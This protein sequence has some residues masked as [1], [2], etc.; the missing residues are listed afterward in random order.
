MPLNT[1]SICRPGKFGNPFKVTPD[2][3][4]EQAV[5]AFRHWIIADDNGVRFPEEKKRIRDNLHTLK[6]KNL[7]CFCKAGTACHGDVLIDLANPLEME[8]IYPFPVKPKV[9]GQVC[10]P[11][12]G[13]ESIDASH[14]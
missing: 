6:G 10:E 3:S 1:V 2:R 7:A 12:A 4:A 5:T 14:E 8:L 9:F 11:D 13:W